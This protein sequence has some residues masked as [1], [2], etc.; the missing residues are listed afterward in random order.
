M[1]EDEC[2]PVQ[3]SRKDSLGFIGGI[4]QYTP[5]EGL[6]SCSLEVGAYLGICY[7]QCD[8]KKSALGMCWDCIGL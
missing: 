5:G 7:Q 8:L 6:S 3:T 4:W 2:S 1:R